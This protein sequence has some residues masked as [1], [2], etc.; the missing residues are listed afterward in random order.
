MSESI[1]SSAVDGDLKIELVQEKH[2]GMWHTGPRDTI[3]RITHIPTGYTAQMIAS[4][5]RTQMQAKALALE[6][7]MKIVEA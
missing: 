6:A 3:I 4:P 2:E 7:L 1:V 5:E